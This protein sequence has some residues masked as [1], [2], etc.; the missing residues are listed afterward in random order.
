M[1][2]YFTTTLFLTH[3]WGLIFCVFLHLFNLVNNNLFTETSILGTADMANNIKNKKKGK[4][5]S[6]PS[7]I[8]VAMPEK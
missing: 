1:S 5:L 6:P 7:T 3:Y 8:Y 4:V 2:K